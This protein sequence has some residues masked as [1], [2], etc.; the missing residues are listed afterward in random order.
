MAATPPA[1]MMIED[2]EIGITPEMID[3]A[4]DALR[5]QIWEDGTLMGAGIREAIADV[6]RA[7]LQAHRRADRPNSKA[8]G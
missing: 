7:G 5:P 6:L 3:A 1:Q 2:D 4:L 8:D